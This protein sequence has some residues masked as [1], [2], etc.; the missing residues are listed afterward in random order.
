M[1][2]VMG[3]SARNRNVDI[4]GAKAEVTKIMASDPRRI[5]RIEIR[6]LMPPGTYSDVE[7]RVLDTAART[8][9]VAL[10]LG[11]GVEQAIELV[12]H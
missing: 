12:W 11:E 1:L 9:P 2:T 3:I 10:S 5:A 8:C 6:L 4:S 7:K